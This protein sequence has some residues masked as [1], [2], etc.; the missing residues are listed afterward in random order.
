MT[1]III[2]TVSLAMIV[3]LTLIH[4]KAVKLW[5]KENAKEI[6]T[7]KARYGNHLTLYPKNHS[8]LRF[9]NTIFLYI[10]LGYFIISICLY[11]F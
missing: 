5:Q 7:Y 6:S 9:I 8:K 11:I 1:H 2:S 4:I 3:F 10:S